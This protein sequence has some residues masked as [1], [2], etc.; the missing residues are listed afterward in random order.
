MMYIVLQI[1]QRIKVLEYRLGDM[2]MIGQNFVQ[3]VC[4]E[5]MARLEIQKLPEIK[6]AQV[7][8]FYYSV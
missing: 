1:V 6:A 8:G 3:T 5:M 2:L 4:R 7:I